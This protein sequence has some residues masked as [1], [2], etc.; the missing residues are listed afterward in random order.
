M[1]SQLK[2]VDQLRLEAEQAM[3]QASSQRASLEMR[4]KIEIER[5]VREAQ[6]HLEK[7]GASDQAQTLDVLLLDFNITGS[8]TATRG[9]HSRRTTD[10]REPLPRRKTTGAERADL[11]VQLPRPEWTGWTFPQ[12]RS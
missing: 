6:H 3:Q 5:L 11:A 8:H 1:C 10:S 2:D 9:R 7:A 4:A 12:Q